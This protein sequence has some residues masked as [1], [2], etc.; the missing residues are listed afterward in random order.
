MIFDRHERYSNNMMGNFE[1][2][3]GLEKFIEKQCSGLTLRGVLD[4][5]AFSNE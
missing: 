3:I 2:R 4:L 5:F 1:K